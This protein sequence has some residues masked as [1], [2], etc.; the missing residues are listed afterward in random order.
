MFQLFSLSIKTLLNLLI[1]TEYKAGKHL[2]SNVESSVAD[3]D[4]SFHCDTDPDSA[5]HRSDA[6]LRP[7]GLETPF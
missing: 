3:P 6:N 1:R 4:S 7:T 5:S 2:F